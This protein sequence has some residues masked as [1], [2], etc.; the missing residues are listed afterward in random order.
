MGSPLTPAPLRIIFG[1]M[2]DK[3]KM[4]VSVNLTYNHKKNQAYPTLF[5]WEGELKKVQK[6]DLHHSYRVGRVLYHVF[7]V[8]SAGAFFRLVLNTENLAWEVDEI[9]CD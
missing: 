9:S 8:S 4:P 6:V 1:C 2:L 7:S 5:K 3:V